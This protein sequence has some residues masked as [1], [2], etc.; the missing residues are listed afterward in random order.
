MLT[1]KS[2]PDPRWLILLLLA[3]PAWTENIRITVLHT[4]DIHGWVM[5]R[6]ATFYE[7][8]PQRP[9]GGAASLAALVKKTKG[10]KLVLDAGDWFQGTPEG[11]FEQGQGLAAVFNTVGYDAMEVG[12]HDFDNGEKNLAAIIGKLSVPVLCANVY[13]A[14]GSRAPECKPWIIKEVAGV[15]VGIFGLLTTSMRA[16][17]FPEN[18]KG[19][20]FRRAVAEANEQVAAL[21]H[22]G[23]SVI[24]AITHQ[25]VERPD[26]ASF[27]GDQTLAAQVEGIDLIVGGHTHTVLKEGLRDATYGTLIVQAGTEMTRVGRVDLEIDPKT[28]KVVRSSARLVSLWPDETGSDPEAVAAVAKLERDVG[29]VYD[30][31]V[32]TA[33]VALMR[34]PRG[35]SSLGDWITD[36][37]RAWAGADIAIQNTRGIRADLPAGPVTLRSIFY[38]APFENHVTKLVMKGRDLKSLLT[39]GA[40]VS[41]VPQISGAILTIRRGAQAG[42]SLVSAT[43]AGKP[44]QDDASYMVSTIDFLAYGGGGYTDFEF[45]E[46]KEFTQMLMRDVLKECAQKEGLIKPPPAGRIIFTE[47]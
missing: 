23:A 34:N 36:C 2:R 8:D 10:P 29:H 14:D 33:A 16:L 13:R 47:D 25:G 15:K 1:Q 26:M 4:N 40:S 38:V 44:I 19:L 31:V 39:H 5:E 35:E 22:E 21:R 43:I 45:A 46:K 24:I 32:A 6:P 37:S 17:S 18:I 7:K 28:K 12:N 11:A 3:A 9:V 30:A 41:G 42:Q 27:E 20:T